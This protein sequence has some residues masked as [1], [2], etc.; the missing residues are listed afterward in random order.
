[1]RR[2]NEGLVSKP[3]AAPM[4]RKSSLRE[5]GED[6][7]PDT[8]WPVR[9]VDKMRA[10]VEQ[11]SGATPRPA[12][13]STSRSTM[14]NDIATPRR[15]DVT[16]GLRRFISKAEHSPPLVEALRSATDE[17]LR[18]PLTARE[19]WRRAGDA[20]R[21][22]HRRFPTLLNASE[23]GLS[24]A[25]PI[26]QSVNVTLDPRGDSLVLRWARFGAI[27]R[28]ECALNQWPVA[29]I[30]MSDADGAADC[31]PRLSS[32]S[33]AASSKSLGQ[34]MRS[35][36][37]GAG[38]SQGSWRRSSQ[39]LEVP[40]T[41]TESSGGAMKVEEVQ[42]IE[43]G[44]ERSDA[45]SAGAAPSPLPVAAPAADPPLLRQGSS[46]DGAAPPL[47]RQGSHKERAAPPLLRQGSH[48]E[49]AGPPPLSK[50]GSGAGSAIASAA[51]T[52]CSLAR[53]M[54]SARNV[55]AGRKVVASAQPMPPGV[56]KQVGALLL[57]LVSQWADAAKST[58]LEGANLLH[59]LLIADT[60]ESLLLAEAVLNARPLLL[61]S[62][63][64]SRSA[65][66][67][68]EGQGV[69]HILA[70]NGRQAL[71]I[72]CV[73]LARRALGNPALTAFFLGKAGGPCR[74]RGT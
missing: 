12:G 36:L 49:R 16:C 31:S 19:R 27:E 72:R 62:V 9:L 23:G 11:E 34:R 33:G 18:P 2:L 54:G 39:C 47:L 53:L 52:V 50:M 57:Q 56:E 69:L 38:G 71:A 65:T 7:L 17:S 66:C 10:D 5:L 63:F 8:T 45:L 32:G 43:R 25:L 22:A 44:A 51:Q 60:T 13:D 40:A 26:F 73:D 46:K 68:F 15:L 58:G 70:V 55:V 61:L 29:A 30:A 64:N 37:A 42:M 48:K 74:L 24:N 35:A 41:I 20:I 28:G 3:E 59:C 21:T 14:G 6:E 4:G 1:M 67:S